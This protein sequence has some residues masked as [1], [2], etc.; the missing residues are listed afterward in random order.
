MFSDEKSK[1]SY[2]YGGSRLKLITAYDK[3]KAVVRNRLCQRL[4]AQL[5]SEGVGASTASKGGSKAIS[6]SYG[7]KNSA[8]TKFS[9]FYTYASESIEMF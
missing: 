3:E 9:K 4:D 1:G 6:S 8:T 7:R 2:C 5:S